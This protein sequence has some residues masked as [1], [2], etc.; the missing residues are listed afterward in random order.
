VPWNSNMPRRPRISSPT[1]LAWSD[2]SVGR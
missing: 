2:W 1:W